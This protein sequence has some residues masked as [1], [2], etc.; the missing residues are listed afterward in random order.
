MRLVQFF[1]ASLWRGL[2]DQDIEHPF[3]TEGPASVNTGCQSG[4]FASRHRSTVLLFVRPRLRRRR[5]RLS[6][7]GRQ[8]PGRGTTAAGVPAWA[9]G[10]SKNTYQ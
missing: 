8:W 2:S 3:R 4:C 1:K 10:I 7:S 5:G 9:P 6:M